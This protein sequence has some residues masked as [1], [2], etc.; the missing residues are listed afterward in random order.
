L[1]QS[2]L[3]LLKL[4]NTIGAASRIDA[5]LENEILSDL[6]WLHKGADPKLRSYDALEWVKQT[7]ASKYINQ[8]E[9]VKA[10]CFKSNPSFYLIDQ[11]VEAMKVFLDKQ[12]KTAFEQVCAE[13]YVMQKADLLEYQAI[14][15]SLDDKIGDAITLLE[16]AGLQGELP[17]N[18]FNGRI[19]DCHDCDHAVPQKIKYTKLSLLKKMKEMED[20]I[21]ASEDVYNNA[22]LLAHAHYNITHYGNARYFYESKVLGSGHYSPFAIDSVYKGFLTN[23]RNAS[24]Y[25]SLALKFAQTDEQKAKCHYMLAKC[26]RNQWY[27]ETFYNNSANEYGETTNGDFRAWNG[28]Q[29]LK[30]LPNTQYYKEVIRECGYFRSYVRK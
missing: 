27:N 21:A 9:M 17:G 12:K 29:A 7:M 10:E 2:Q 18:P 25:Y 24:K 8:K 22:L 26:E 1:V 6:N 19:Q 30:L 20:K 15:L 11:N 5:R 4:I 23:M 28:F 3:R 14:R 16:Q 13:L